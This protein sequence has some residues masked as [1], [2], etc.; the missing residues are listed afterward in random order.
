MGRVDFTSGA[1]KRRE[2]SRVKIIASVFTILVIDLYRLD[3]HFISSSHFPQR[4]KQERIVFNK[5]E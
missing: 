4:G 3:F 2:R 5:Y 1:S